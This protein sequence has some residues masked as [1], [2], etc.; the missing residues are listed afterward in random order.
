M[1]VF[2]CSVGLLYNDGQMYAKFGKHAFPLAL[3]A[4]NMVVDLVREVS[5]NGRLG[6][7]NTFLALYTLRSHASLF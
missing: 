3:N 5:K 2:V 6:H 4:T 7:V 1:K